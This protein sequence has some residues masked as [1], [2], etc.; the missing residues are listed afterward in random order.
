MPT[1]EQ[2]AW[3]CQAEGRPVLAEHCLTAA[4]GA[5]SAVV[6]AAAPVACMPESCNLPQ[7]V[8]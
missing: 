3:S 8:T 6:A 4:R 2:V 7:R 1:A 5:A